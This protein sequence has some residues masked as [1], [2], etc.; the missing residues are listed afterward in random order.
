MKVDISFVPADECKTLVGT[1]DKYLA[2]GLDTDTMVC[3]GE[4]GKDTCQGDSGGPLILPSTPW[5]TSDCLAKLVG[6]TS[7]GPRICGMTSVPGVYVRVAHFLPW[8]ESI[9]WP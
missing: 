3:A 9:V 4:L 7:F 2:N 1:I 5:S 8:I 6:V